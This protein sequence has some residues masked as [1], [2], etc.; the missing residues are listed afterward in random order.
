MGDLPW[1]RQRANCDESIPIS[2]ATTPSQRLPAFQHASDRWSR[3]AGHALRGLTACSLIAQLRQ[4][5]ARHCTQLDCLRVVLS[6]QDFA[7]IVPTSRPSE[8]ASTPLVELYKRLFSEP[9]LGHL[10]SLQRAVFEYDKLG[11][12]PSGAPC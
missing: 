4:N 5:G 2:W 7:P 10:R 6:Q 3:R 12:E 8:G 11:T 9:D 1:P